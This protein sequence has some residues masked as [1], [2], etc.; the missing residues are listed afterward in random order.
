MLLLE[1]LCASRY[2]S[3]RC[4]LSFSAPIHSSPSGENKTK[5]S[6]IFCTDQGRSVW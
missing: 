3:S 5:Q 4:L 2:F 1:Y 6:M